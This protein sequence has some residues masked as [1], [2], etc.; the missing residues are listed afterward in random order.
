M[1]LDDGSS[2]GNPSISW[3]MDPVPPRRSAGGDIS[4]LRQLVCASGRY[5][6]RTIVVYHGN[7]TPQRE[8]CVGLLNA[9]PGSSIADVPDG[10]VAC[11]GT[12]AGRVGFF[13]PHAAGRG[14]ILVHATVW[15]LPPG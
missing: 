2:D 5:A 12:Q 1:T 14:Q 3:A 4:L 10:T 8:E 15:E 7:S 6:G 11:F 13:T 9:N